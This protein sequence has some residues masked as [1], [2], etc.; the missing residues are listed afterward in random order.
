MIKKIFSH[1]LIYGV[2]PQLPRL[3]SFFILP[4]ITKFLTTS[5]YGIFTI[6]VSYTAMLGAIKDLGLKV[7]LS[8]T[9]FKH[10]NHIKKIWGQ[11]YGFLFLWN[12]LFG[13]LIVTL[14]Y[15]VIPPE[16][17]ENKWKI[18]ALTTLPIIFF[19]Q[20]MEI[21]QLYYQLKKKPLQIGIRAAIIGTLA[22]FLNYYT[23]AILKLGY[24]GFF[25]STF[26]SMMLYNISYW[27]P[28]NYKELIKPIFK[29]KRRFIKESLKIGM[30][31]IPHNIAAY[32][33]RTSDRVVMERLDVSTDNLGSYGFAGNFGNLFGTVA[34]ATNTAISP[35]LL[36]NYKNNKDL[37]ARNLI[38]IWQIGLLIICSIS[39]LWLK[40]VFSFLA[41]KE[42]FKTLYSIAILL[43]MAQ[44]Y[45]PMYVGGLQ[46]LFFLNKTKQLFKVTLLS[47]VINV[48]LN[49]IFIPKFGFEFAVISGY[50]SLLVQGYIF[51]SFKSFKSVNP[52]KFYPLFWLALQIA[53]SIAVYFLRDIELIYKVGLSIFVMIAGASAL[54]KLS[55][56]LNG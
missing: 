31:L 2:A 25:I 48:V 6:V 13:L 56:K 41:A 16:A 35:F 39:C 10:N 45:R 18:I 43:I 28:L 54:Y 9:F 55:N 53:L 7:V 15:F 17:Q 29:F 3:A 26:A 27:I 23:I 42:E 32:L 8:N 40:E 49:L 21:G 38:F 51:Y 30:P 20:T 14:L 11:I 46:K 50:I 52:V 22:V 33:Q 1:S 37:T 44:C 24:M 19:G 5:D 36:E 4:I 47:G 12:I 34:Q